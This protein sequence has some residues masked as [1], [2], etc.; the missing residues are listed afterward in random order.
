MFR[1][2]DTRDMSTV[3]PSV[4]RA[5]AEM[6]ESDNLHFVAYPVAMSMDN[7]NY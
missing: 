4:S 5:F 1:V 2:I 3:F 6:A 7:I